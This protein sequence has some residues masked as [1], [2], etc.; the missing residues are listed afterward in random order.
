MATDLLC[1]VAEKHRVISL[2]H[3][4]VVYVMFY[5]ACATDPGTVTKENVEKACK[6]FPYDNVLF[7]E[8][9]CATCNLQKYDR[10]LCLP[11][12]VLVL[13]DFWF[14]LIIEKLQAA[15]VKAL[16]HVQQ[17]CSSVRP[18]VRTT[19]DLIGFRLVELLLIFFLFLVFAFAVPAAYGK[20]QSTLISACSLS[21]STWPSRSLPVK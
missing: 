8:R 9:L 10:S 16:L 7:E 4:L 12:L 14:G 13:A 2:L 6:M 15:K 17:V 3:I 1:V 19:L 21:L 18:P 11:F 5:F 20:F